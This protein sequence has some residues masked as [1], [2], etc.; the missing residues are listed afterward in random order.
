[1]N[2][3]SKRQLSA[4]SL[5]S[6]KT[7]SALKIESRET[8]F[9]EKRIND[10]SFQNETRNRSKNISRIFFHKRSKE[11]SSS[12]VSHTSWGKKKNRER[13]W[14]INHVESQR[15]GIPLVS[16]NGMQLDEDGGWECHDPRRAKRRHKL[17]ICLDKR[18][19]NGKSSDCLFVPERC[20]LST[21]T[22]HLFY[23]IMLQKSDAGTRG[24]GTR[25]AYMRDPQRTLVPAFCDF[26]LN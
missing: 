18:Q 26:H 20:D 6:R 21:T 11:Q 9:R 4:L 5:H 3:E 13:S 24:A 23:Q 14:G 10:V 1:M 15:D 7:D 2:F 17:H 8:E 19:Q 25:F 16:R 22:A 12:Q